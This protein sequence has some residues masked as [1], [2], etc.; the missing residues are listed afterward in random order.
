MQVLY[1]VLHVQVTYGAVLLGFLGAMH[2]GLE[3]AKYGGEQGTFTLNYYLQVAA[4]TT[5]FRL[6]AARAGSRTCPVCVAHACACARGSVGNSVGW[7]HCL[8]ESDRANVRAATDM[9]G[10]FSGMLILKQLRPDGVSN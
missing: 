8:G 10:C 7:L 6:Q 2:W 9:G 4:L 5:T 3:F 1:Q